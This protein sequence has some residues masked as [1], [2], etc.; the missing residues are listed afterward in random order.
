MAQSEF[1]RSGR[2]LH[3]GPPLDARLVRTGP[4]WQA[5][6]RLLSEVRTRVTDAPCPR[7][8]PSAACCEGVASGNVD[9]LHCCRVDISHWTPLS[10]AR[11]I[12]VRRHAGWRPESGFGIARWVTRQKCRP[13]GAGSTTAPRPAV[14]VRDVSN[15]YSSL[16]LPPAS[17]NDG[18]APKTP[19]A[20]HPQGFRSNG[21]RRDLLQH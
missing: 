17:S 8:G 1:E 7:H 11:L 4:I 3:N 13:S 18:N 21:L 19:K 16:V 6:T 14:S 15:W 2:S 20:P 9:K 12:L 5:A 10:R